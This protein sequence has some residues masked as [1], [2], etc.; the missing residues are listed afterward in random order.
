MSFCVCLATHPSYKYVITSLFIC[1]SMLSI[2]VSLFI[3]IFEI[4][5]CINCFL[6]WLVPMLMNVS[7]NLVIISLTNSYGTGSPSARLTSCFSSCSLNFNFS[8]V[9]SFTH[10]STISSLVNIVSTQNSSFSLCSRTEYA[11]SFR[12]HTCL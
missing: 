3:V 2:S 12:Q 10:I 1:I 9:V 4:S 7:L 5:K 8:I 6:C 11:Y